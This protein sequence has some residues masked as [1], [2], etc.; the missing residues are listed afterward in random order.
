MSNKP[1]VNNKMMTDILKQLNSI[2]LSLA[3]PKPKQQRKR[4]SKAAKKQNMKPNS[5]NETQSKFGTVTAKKPNYTSPYALCRLA[6]F[7]ERGIT[8]FTGIPDGDNSKRIIIDHTAYTDFSFS[9]GTATFR[10]LPGL[11]YGAAANFTSGTVVNISDPVQSTLVATIGSNVPSINYWIPVCAFPEYQQQTVTQSQQSLANP[12]GAVKI[13]IVGVAWRLIYTGKAVD[14]NGLITIRDMPMSIADGDIILPQVLACN[15]A[16]TANSIN[17]G[18]GVPMDLTPVSTTI[19]NSILMR[20]ES[21]P[22]G[23]L[24]HNSRVYRWRDYFEQ[25]RIPYDSRTVSTTINTSNVGEFFSINLIGYQNGFNAWDTDFTGCE[26]SIKGIVG[27]TSDYRLEVKT[28]VEYLIPPGGALYPLLKS[29][30]KPN[31]PIVEKVGETIA[32][33]PPA[34]DWSSHPK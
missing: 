20:P 14:T 24:K 15:A 7:S 1:K 23:I 33:S 12:Y 4:K 31:I 8:T 9:Q 16:N 11:P 25:S 34:F 3:I 21:N 28:C 29:P 26:I 30:P 17:P 22:W 32:Q 2:K 13:R 6:P 5:L 27:V 19:P 18:I 10:I